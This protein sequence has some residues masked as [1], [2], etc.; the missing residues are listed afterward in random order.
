MVDKEIEYKH[1]ERIPMQ[2]LCI[3]ASIVESNELPEWLFGDNKIS[4][5]VYVGCWIKDQTEKNAEYIAKGQ[6][7]EYS[8][9]AEAIEVQHPITEKY[10]EDNDEYD[11]L[12]YYEQALIDG[13]VLVF[14][15]SPAEEDDNKKP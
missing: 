4:E 2:Y 10:Y 9:I 13:E 6:I 11:H 7:E 14:N 5:E 3:R 12:Q 15:T 1:Y 8:I